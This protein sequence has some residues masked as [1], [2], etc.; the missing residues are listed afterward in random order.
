[1]ICHIYTRLAVRYEQ[2]QHFEKHCLVEVCRWRLKGQRVP[3]SDVGYAFQVTQPQAQV[4]TYLLHHSHMKLATSAS[5]RAQPPPPACVQLQE[6]V[7][8]WPESEKNS[9]ISI[10]ICVNGVF[11]SGSEGDHVGFSSFPPSVVAGILI[12]RTGQYFH[13]FSACSAVVASAAVF[14]FVSFCLLDRKERNSAQVAQP[15]TLPEQGRTSISVA[16]S[17]QYSSVPTEGDKDKTSAN[18]AEFITSV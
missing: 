11:C 12:D 3:V 6:L 14:I 10:W 7:Q 1:M 8:N 5:L 4:E 18:G 9:L 15:S 13:V 2:S 16:P 17:C